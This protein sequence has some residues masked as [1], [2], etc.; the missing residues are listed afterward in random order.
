MTTPRPPAR[1][2]DRG[3]AGHQLRPGGHSAGAGHQLTPGSAQRVEV[4]P[5]CRRVP[6]HAGRSKPC[7]WCAHAVGI[8]AT[9]PGSRGA[10]AGHQPGCRCRLF[11]VYRSPFTKIKRHTLRRWCG[12]NHPH[13]K[14][15]QE[16]LEGGYPATQNP[17]A[18]LVCP[19]FGLVFHRGID[20]K[21]WGHWGQLWI[22]NLTH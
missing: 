2:P 21:T 22:T 6:R 3:H 20:K 12:T 5:R 7:T 8:R 19:G 15:L 17:P 9:L 10:G 18:G 13:G 4:V 16:Y 1:G 14:K 11:T